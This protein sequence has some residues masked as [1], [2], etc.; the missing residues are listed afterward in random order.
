MQK[1]EIRFL[2]ALEQIIRQRI[3]DHATDSYTARL[4]AAGVKYAAQ[5]TGEEAVELAL[6]SVTGDVAE[7]KDEAAD[8]LYHMIVLLAL[9]D[10]RL[11]EVVAVLRDRHERS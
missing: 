6:A 1:N 7:I 11:A 2:E 10:V 8:L 5:K 4:A 9:S 3:D